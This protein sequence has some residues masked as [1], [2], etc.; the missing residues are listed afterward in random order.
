MILVILTNI[1]YLA[2]TTHVWGKK[3][4]KKIL[5]HA[6]VFAW[7]IR[8]NTVSICWQVS[9]ELQR[10]LPMSKSDKE[11]G[12]TEAL[13]CFLC[14]CRK[15]TVWK[16][17]LKQTN[18][19]TNMAYLTITMDQVQFGKKG[20][21]R[22]NSLKR[23]A[24]FEQCV[25]ITTMY[26]KHLHSVQFSSIQSLSPVWLLATPWVAARQASLSITNSQNSLKHIFI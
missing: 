10:T 6:S 20:S 11:K 7:I 26:P 22:K 5:G 25:S 12:A 15:L 19:Q 3:K 2:K 23:V 21:W 14:T 8:I 4:K 24:H 17:H 18:K 1:N 13:K 9:E 16:S